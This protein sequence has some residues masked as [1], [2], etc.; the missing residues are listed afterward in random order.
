MTYFAQ[1]FER[2]SLPITKS[3]LFI[4]VKLRQ[5]FVAGGEVR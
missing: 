2:L 1:G 3:K 5:S 4:A